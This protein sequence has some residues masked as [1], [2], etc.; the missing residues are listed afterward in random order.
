METNGMRMTK[1]T[2]RAKRVEM[3]LE[4]IPGKVESTKPLSADA[5]RPPEREQ[6]SQRNGD[7]RG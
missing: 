6:G 3:K 4:T 2:L 1:E 5:R 7:H